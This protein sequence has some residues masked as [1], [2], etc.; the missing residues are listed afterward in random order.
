MNT[1]THGQTG[2]EES[3]IGA[4][5]P[6]THFPKSAPLLSSIMLLQLPR[7]HLPRICLRQ[8]VGDLSRAALLLV[9][10]DTN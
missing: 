7:T 2:Q 5:R 1:S 10:Q 4:V 8:V 6:S 3:G 9:I